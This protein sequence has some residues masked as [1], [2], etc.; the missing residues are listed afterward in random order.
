MKEPPVADLELLAQK[1]LDAAKKAGAG[2]ADAIVIKGDSLSIEVADGALE[3]AERAEGIDLGLRVLIGQRSAVVSVSDASDSTIATMAERAVAMANAAPEDPNVGLAT[4]DQLAKNR[5][6]SALELIDTAAP[7]SP[8]GLKQMA[9]EAEAAALAVSGV[10]KVDSAGGS[11]SKSS[12]HLAASNGFSG[13]YSRTSTGLYCTAI[14]GEGLKMERDYKGDSRIFAADMIG[15]DEI[16][17]IA[18]ERAVALIGASQPPTGAF[19]VLF[20]E[21]VSS[22]LIGH[23]VAAINGRSVARGVSWLKDAMGEYVLPE[24]MDLIEDPARPRVGGSKPFDAEGLPVVQRAWVKNG[25]LQSWVL[26]L[27]SARQLGLQST[28]NAARGAG[29]APGPSVG[30]LTLTPGRA[31]RDELIAQMGTGLIITSMIGSS[32]NPNTGEYSRG[33]SGF[34]VENGKVTRPVNECTV[35]GNLREMLGNMVAA[36][37]GQAHLS[38]VIPS[39]LVEGL[40]IAG[41]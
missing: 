15:A 40:T 25:V 37:D 38:R 18:G 34:W 26:D 22:S 13:G 39:L 1:M 36:N 31:T 12:I 4:P 30:N 29:S 21:R 2:A 41:G 35:A 17:R 27:A 20:D 32:V 10:S 7:A 3:H 5:D 11:Y 28:G 33:A 23:L 6:A 8:D 19:P 14:S 16:G 24:G 9:L